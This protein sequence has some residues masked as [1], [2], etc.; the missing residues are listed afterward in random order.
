M[1]KNTAIIDQESSQIQIV[2]AI[3]NND[4]KVLK[5]L[6]QANYNKVKALVLSINGS[7]AHAKDIYQDAFIAVWKN[8]EIL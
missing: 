5:V 1:Q 4:L 7:I 3:K 6:Y 2:K 8:I